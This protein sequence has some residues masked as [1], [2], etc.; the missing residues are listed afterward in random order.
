MTKDEKYKYK[1]IENYI[2]DGIRNS[3]FAVDSLL[4]TQ[5]ELCRQFDV[6]RT[7]VNR[8]LNELVDCGIVEKIQGSGCYIRTPKLSKQSKQ[9]IF[10]SSFSEEYAG[11]GYKVTTKLLFYT[12]KKIEEFKDPKLAK[13]LGAKPRDYVHYFERL[14]CGNQIPFA[15]Q[16]SYILVKEISTLPISNLE[17]SFY[18]YVENELKLV[19]GD[20]ESE[21]SVILPSPTIAK[22]LAIPE[23]EPVVKIVH[24]SCLKNGLI[25]E[26]VDTYSRYDKFTLLYTNKRDKE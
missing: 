23:T 10:M 11:M 8:A 25:F 21:L 7:T 20:G 9:R 2:Y 13:R 14:R 1:Q 26:Y 24:V 17:K 18:A 3:Q 19:M 5:E 22:L 15:L 12:I 6:S 16:Y 4:P